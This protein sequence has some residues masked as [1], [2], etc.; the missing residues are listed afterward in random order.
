M[1]TRRQPRT[2]ARTNPISLIR[3]PRRPERCRRTGG[4]QRGDHRAG[5][6]AATTASRLAAVARAAAV[7]CV[8]V[9]DQGALAPSPGVAPY[10][11]GP[12]RCS[13]AQLTRA[14]AVGHAKRPYMRVARGAARDGAGRAARP[15][16]RR[17]AEEPALLDPRGCAVAGPSSVGRA[18]RSMSRGRTGRW[19]APASSNRPGHVAHRKGD[20]PLSSTPVALLGVA[21][22]CA[23]VFNNHTSPDVRT[24]WP[25]RSDS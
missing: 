22:P 17:R 3:D 5:P 14:G 23:P 6:R 13:S 16:S 21:D 11:H 15:I 12:G 8:V 9:N 25:G 18:S 7:G 4:E 20:L 19:R 24:P 2:L 1:T 10:V